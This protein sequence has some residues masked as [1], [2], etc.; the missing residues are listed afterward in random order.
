MTQED[1]LQQFEQKDVFG[2]FDLPKSE[3][4]AQ[5]V[6]NEALQSFYANKGA[7]SRKA[8]W[9]VMVIIAVICIFFLPSAGATGIILAVGIMNIFTESKRSSVPV[10]EIDAKESILTLSG[11]KIM[12]NE[13]KSWSADEKNLT[14]F[15]LPA[16]AT[17][18]E[19][20]APLVL[21]LK[22]FEDEVKHNMF[23]ELEKI[24]G[25]PATK[26]AQ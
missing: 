24:F 2:G 23:D 22:G 26:L 12:F 19:K 7:E 10:L 4:A 3:P 5:H 6:Q 1:K 17:E 16:N 9:I 21:N 18:E 14:L 11:S 13:I 15:Y 20:E 8:M 25:E